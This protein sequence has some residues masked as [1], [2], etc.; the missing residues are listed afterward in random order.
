MYKKI[1]WK[2]K[3]TDGASSFVQ[4]ENANRL[5][6]AQDALGRRWDFIEKEPRKVAVIEFDDLTMYQRIVEY[7]QKN[8]MI[9]DFGTGSHE[10]QEDVHNVIVEKGKKSQPARYSFYARPRSESTVLEDA[11]KNVKMRSCHARRRFK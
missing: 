2:E 8:N 7:M 5:K 6:E 4:F 1:P 11:V 10:L 9:V 3:G